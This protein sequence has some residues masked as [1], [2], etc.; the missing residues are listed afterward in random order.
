MVYR[1]RC[2]IDSD[3]INRDHKKEKENGYNYE[4]N[5]YHCIVISII[6]S[7]PSALKRAECRDYAFLLEKAERAHI[8]QEPRK[9]SYE[10]DKVLAKIDTLCKR[11][12]YRPCQRV[13]SDVHLLPPFQ[14]K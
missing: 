10:K 3:N 1:R 5:R 2:F 13:R 9:I 14:A 12:K 11:R 8:G 7:N 4:R 6:P